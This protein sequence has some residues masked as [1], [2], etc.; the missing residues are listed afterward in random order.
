[1]LWLFFFLFQQ[2]AFSYIHAVM[3][4]DQY[5]EPDREEVARAVMQNFKVIVSSFSK[6]KKFI[7]LNDLKL[8]G[9]PIKALLAN[10]SSVCTHSFL[11]S[12]TP[13]P[14]LP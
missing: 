10:K 13:P 9:R 7:S 12:I 2:Q 14:S 8:C 6:F 11:A 5:T 3:N 1:M 4:E